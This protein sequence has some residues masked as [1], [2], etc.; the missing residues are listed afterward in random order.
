MWY[1]HVLIGNTLNNNPMTHITISLDYYLHFVFFSLRK[2]GTAPTHMMRREN[3]HPYIVAYG[4]TRETITCFYIEVEKH[5]IP[6]CMASG[7]DIP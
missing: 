3:N 5:L 1:V 7:S 2:I 6:V 4:P